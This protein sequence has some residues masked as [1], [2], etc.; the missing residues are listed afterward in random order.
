[1]NATPVKSKR[2][3][4]LKGK[5]F[6]PLTVVRLY[7]TDGH[8]ALWT[9]QCQCG[10]ILVKVGTE[11]S[12]KRRVP[13]GCSKK[14]P[15]SISIL[16]KKRTTHGM[17]KHPVH[18]VW[19]SMTQRCINPR[20][21]A[22]HNY[23]GRGIGVCEEWLDDF[24][25]FWADMGPAYQRGLDIDRRDNNAGYSKENC[26]WVTRTV[27]TRNRRNCTIAGEIIDRCRENGIGRSTME[28]R[29]RRGVKPEIACSKKPD[30]RNRFTTSETVGREEGS[31]SEELEGFWS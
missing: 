4:D 10:N 7:G 17:S 26:R 18:A 20:H 3:V 2:L 12:K 5:Q 14:C 16:S 15:I 6:G 23:G 30:L 9:V 8:K 29:I 28:W 22:Y 13:V 25:Q 31:P 21:A 11:I 27:N 1:M 24:A 19:S